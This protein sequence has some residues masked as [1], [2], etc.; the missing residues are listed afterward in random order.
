MKQKWFAGAAAMLMLTGLLASLTTG[1]SKQEEA[2]SGAPTAEQTRLEQ[3]A[4]Q[5]AAANAAAA[6][7][8]QHPN[9]APAPR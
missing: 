1:C 6:N 4:G 5:K 2:P 8:Q 3:D 9:G 7:A